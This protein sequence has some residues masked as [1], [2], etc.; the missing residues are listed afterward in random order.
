MVQSVGCQVGPYRSILLSIEAALLKSTQYLLLAGEVGLRL[1]VDLVE[2]D[3][4]LEVGLIEA[5]IDPTVHQLPEIHRLG[6]VRLPLAEHLA[7]LLHQCRLFLGLLFCET[8]CL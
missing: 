5:G 4:H 3:P 8:F 1:V 7:C 2:G 6:I